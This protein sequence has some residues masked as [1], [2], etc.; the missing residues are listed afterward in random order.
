MR[1]EAKR[2][3][4]VSSIITSVA[5]SPQASARSALPGASEELLDQAVLGAGREGRRAH[6]ECASRSVIWRAA[7]ASGA[8]E[9]ST[10][11]M[12]FMGRLL[13]RSGFRD[14]ERP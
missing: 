2:H 5:S 6:A 11:A 13:T 9:D 12:A 3:E 7:C 4:H 8:G 14:V 10:V 1:D